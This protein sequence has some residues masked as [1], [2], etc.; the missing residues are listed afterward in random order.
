MSHVTVEW[1]SNGHK[2]KKQIEDGQRVTIGRHPECDII[3]GDP[4][5][6]R[7]HASIYFR[8]GAFHILNL[9]RTNPV[10]L[11]DRWILA[12][13]LETHIKPGDNLTVGLVR[14]QITLSKITAGLKASAPLG[15]SGSLF[16]LLAF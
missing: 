2:R 11:N 16:S 15:D 10:I 5:V 3:L 12:D 13:D 8:D 1:L 4:H 6:S 14:L 9:S 7:R